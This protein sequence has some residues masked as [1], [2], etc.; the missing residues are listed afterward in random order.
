MEEIKTLH[1]CTIFSV[2]MN[3]L[4]E[5][6][7]LFFPFAL[8]YLSQYIRTGNESYLLCAGILFGTMFYVHLLTVIYF[9]LVLMVHVVISFLTN[10]KRKLTLR[11]VTCTVA[12]GS[13][14][15]FPV[16]FQIL[17]VSIYYGSFA[18]CVT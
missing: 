2:S 15:S 1:A 7:G 13:L 8:M 18:T 10:E 16:S 17:P 6:I 12:L 14:L 9:V 11:A 5:H 3:P 4:T